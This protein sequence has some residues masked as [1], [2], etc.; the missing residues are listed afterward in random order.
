VSDNAD[1]KAHI[2]LQCGFEDGAALGWPE[3]G[4]APG[5]RW[6]DIPEDRSCP[7]RGASNADFAMMEKTRS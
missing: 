7:D 1:D 2:C 4:I 3:G 6:D 5:T